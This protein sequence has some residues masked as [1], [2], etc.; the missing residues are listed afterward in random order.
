[1]QCACGFF[2]PFWGARH[3]RLE[4]AGVGIAAAAAAAAVENSSWQPRARPT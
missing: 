3:R 2:P 1:M 4:R